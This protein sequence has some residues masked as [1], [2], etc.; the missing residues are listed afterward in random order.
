VPS[1][2]SRLPLMIAC[3]RP[4]EVQCCTWSGEACLPPPLPS[5]LYLTL[6]LH[7]GG[8]DRRLI[9]VRRAVYVHRIAATQRG[10][11]ALTSSGFHAGAD[12][13]LCTAWHRLAEGTR[14]TPR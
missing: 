11:T 4:N 14:E 6:T 10:E 5:R 12:V 8:K 7:A 13:A 9:N 3:R 1:A 2:L